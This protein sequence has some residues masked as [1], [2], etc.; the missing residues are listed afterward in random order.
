M[1]GT[2]VCGASTLIGSARTMENTTTFSDAEIRKFTAMA[3]EWWDPA[4]SFRPLHQ[5]NPVRVA[6]IRERVAWHY[7]RNPRADR[8][9]AGLRIIDIGCG[10][11]L[12]AEPLAA[13]GAEVVA[14]DA[15]PK[16]VAIAKIHAEQGGLAIDYRCAAPEQ[17]AEN[18]QPFDAVIS[19]EVVEH[20]SDVDAFIATC[21]RLSRPGGILILA[22]LNRTLKSLVVAKIGAEYVL[23]LLPR[24]THDW[25]KFIRPSELAAHLRRNQ[26]KL[27]DLVGMELSPLKGRWQLSKDVK[28][29][30]IMTGVSTEATNT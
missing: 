30:Y 2:S 12:V 3:D 23:R 24:G 13:M 4:G 25:R 14:V 11:G 26:F 17:L 27:T 18:E 20:V 10:G 15:D 9:L 28:I 7:G 21:N 1:S 5:L 19:M 29:N 16:A 22:T 6:A 8:P